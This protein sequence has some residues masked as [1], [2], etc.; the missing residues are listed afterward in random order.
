MPS[1]VLWRPTRGG[2]RGSYQAGGGDASGTPS[3]RP[4]VA[5]TS[6]SKPVGSATTPCPLGAIRVTVQW[7]DGKPISGAAVS[8]GAGDEKRTDT[9]GTASFGKV[10]PGEYTVS[11]RLDPKSGGFI[12]PPPCTLALEASSTASAT[13]E[14]EPLATV[15]VKVK[16]RK[17]GNGIA[18][19]SVALIGRDIPERA[20]GTTDAK[21]MASIAEVRHG[22]Y[23]VRGTI[24]SAD[25][26]RYG[27]PV[28]LPEVTIPA[29]RPIE[30]EAAPL[31]VQAVRVL[32]KPIGKGQQATALGGVTVRLSPEHGDPIELVTD[33]ANGT[34]A[35][36]GV[37]PGTYRL[38]LDLGER[39]GRFKAVPAAELSIDAPTNRE[40]VIELEAVSCQLKGITVKEILSE[41]GPGGRKEKAGRTFA[42]RTA[43]ASGGSGGGIEVKE[44]GP[45]QVVA[46]RRGDLFREIPAAF[47]PLPFN[48]PSSDLRPNAAPAWLEVEIDATPHPAGT[49]ETG[50][51]PLVVIQNG[52][53][54]QL[55]RAAGSLKT[56][57]VMFWGP[58][59]DWST[60]QPEPGK[61]RRFLSGIG[62]QLAEVLNAVTRADAAP[63]F[64]DLIAQVC[65]ESG[66]DREIRV[67]VVV[68][69]GDRYQLKV[70][71][72]PLLAWKWG[73]NGDY[74]AGEKLT[75]SKEAAGLVREKSQQEATAG[76]AGT[77]TKAQQGR[78]ETATAADG[79][80]TV[81]E[82]T[83]F[84]ALFQAE[85][86]NPPPIE[87]T[88][89]GEPIGSGIAIDLVKGVLFAATEMTQWFGDLG[90]ITP[91]WG[92]W[93]TAEVALLKVSV[94]GTWGWTPAEKKNE[95]AWVYK[96]QMSG[97]LL[98]VKLGIKAG[99]EGTVVPSLVYFRAVVYLEVS[100]TADCEWTWTSDRQPT[101]QNV[102]STASL[103]VGVDLVIGNA[104]FCQAKSWVKVPYTF[105]WNLLP[106]AP[107]KGWEVQ[108]K[109]GCKDGIYIVARY[110]LFY[111]K[112]EGTKKV[113]LKDPVDL[114]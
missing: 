29:A 31:G 7:T 103:E 33:D 60:R 68:Y 48:P 61:P 107:P 16:D 102:A 72:P 9:T 99:L 2:T 59:V 36:E 15:P 74:I 111:G 22:R 18:G 105:Q 113:M 35:F 1:K 25:E 50:Q 8:I 83:P 64:W 106:P 110:K 10:G 98:E 4:T 28:P 6:S 78:T 101:R 51:H 91:K 5:G 81:I 54:D 96:L 37:Q 47:S 17:T 63:A 100:G 69:P 46:P 75:T 84:T 88:R 21:G 80:Q 89:N 40:R 39:T 42:I 87:F 71:V 92:W 79:T 90:N 57:R 11:V 12:P 26:R 55:A 86:E 85:Y 94:G 108:F 32:R 67:P 41:A 93:V 27:K 13:I 95:V 3:P 43:G 49:S 19:V 73:V 30:L 45:L 56:G 14:V 97:T 66:A 65:D 76:A 104:N 44:G 58:D 24:G 23:E 77:E 82:H 52:S 112:Y 114:D 20:E 38:E 53:G 70:T 62:N 34:V 109:H